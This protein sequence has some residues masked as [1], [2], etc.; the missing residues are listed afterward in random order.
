MQR[1]LFQNNWNDLDELQRRLN[2]PPAPPEPEIETVYIAD[3][4]QGT[5]RLGYSDFNPRLMA[6]AQG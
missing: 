2:P 1:M 5:A 4:E 6:R 3:G